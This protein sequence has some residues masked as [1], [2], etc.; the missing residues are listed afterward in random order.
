MCAGFTPKQAI[1]AAKK[2]Q[3]EKSLSSTVALMQVQS[4]RFRNR[5]L[6]V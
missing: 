3:L 4:E 2:K 6:S 5:F 1:A